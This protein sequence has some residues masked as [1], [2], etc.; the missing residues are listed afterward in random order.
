MA[1]ATVA[2]DRLK[3]L[4]VAHEL[5]AQITLNHPLI[6]SDDVK[7]FVQLLFTESFCT[8]V[9]INTDFFNDQVGADRTDSV[10]ITEGKRDFLLRGNIN[11]ENTW[12]R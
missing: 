6:F 3:A 5:A 2:I 12:H 4:Q 8:G 1:N 11:T 7:N 9:G 10:N